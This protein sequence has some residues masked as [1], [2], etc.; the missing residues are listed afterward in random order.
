MI[1]CTSYEGFGIPVLEAMEASKPI[2]CSDIEVLR[3]F[4]YDGQFFYKNKSPESL[5][6]QIIKVLH[7]PKNTV[8][9]SSQLK[10]Y[11]W[12]NIVN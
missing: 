7:Q 9:I 6:N 3:E 10:K 12:N 5:K 11:D 4:K 2:I 8:S 1:F